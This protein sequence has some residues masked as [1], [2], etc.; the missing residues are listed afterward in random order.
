MYKRAIITFIFLTITF[1]SAFASNEGF[2]HDGGSGGVIVP[3]TITTY[4]TEPCALDGSS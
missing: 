2:E 1:G 3:G 4:T